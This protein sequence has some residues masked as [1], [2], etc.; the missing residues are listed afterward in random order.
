MTNI[1]YDFAS[2]A[3]LREN[4]LMH[5]RVF[6][7]SDVPPPPPAGQEP[8]PEIP[9]E[10]V[11]KSRKTLYAI[12]GTVAVVAVIIAVVFISISS[13][14]AG[15][16]QNI[17]YSVSYN[18][19][20][21]C[22]YS[23]SMSVSASGQTI[24]G[25]GTEVMTVASFDGDNYTLN[26]VT[27]AETNGQP[28]NS[29]ITIIMNKEGK[30]VGASNLPSDV[31]SAYSLIEGSP[32]SSIYFNQSTIQVGKTYQFPINI[33]NSTMSFSGTYNFK[34]ADI[35]TITVPAGTYKTFKLEFSTSNFQGTMQGVTVD[36]S[37]N[38]YIH[39]DYNKCRPVDF[40]LQG[41]ESAQGYTLNLSMSM[42]LTSDTT[43]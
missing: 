20:E 23:I 6:S 9:T 8:I 14:P 16:G 40:N 4:R 25:T 2:F 34:V 5:M 15:Y 43:Q 35:E 38:G 11:T 32:G 3:H 26:E 27:N 1:K 41:S 17:P 7:D 30:M 10:P 18:V 33:G 12:I 42:Q 28:Y 39:M 36:L 24:T 22:T 29:N 31:Q 21:Q 19:G 13:V 37:F